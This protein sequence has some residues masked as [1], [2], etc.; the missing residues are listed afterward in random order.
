[1]LQRVAATTTLPSRIDRINAITA[2]CATGKSDTSGI[3]SLGR[4]L[5]R[6]LGQ[7]RQSC[8]LG[9]RQRAQFLL[10]GRQMALLLSA[11]ACGLYPPESA[12]SHCQEPGK[13]LAI[14]TCSNESPLLMAE[15]FLTGT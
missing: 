2:I 13:V 1:M 11:P 7:T 12:S 10:R 9:E 8:A 3:D 14:A 4:G 5:L 6:F 15:G